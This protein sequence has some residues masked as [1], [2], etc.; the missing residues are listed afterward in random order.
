MFRE[1]LFAITAKYPEML[2]LNLRFDA[3]LFKTKES[4]SKVQQ[5][6]QVYFMQGGSQVQMNV[7]DTKALLDAMEHPEAHRD[8]IVRVG[9]FSDNFSLL[10]KRIQTEVLKRTAHNI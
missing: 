5:L 7:L 6:L 2:L 10:E 1:F 8:I 3:S 9:G 4:T